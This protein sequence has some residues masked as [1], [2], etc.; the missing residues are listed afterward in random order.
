VSTKSQRGLDVFM[1]LGRRKIAGRNR[2]MAGLLVLALAGVIGV[3]AYAFTASNSVP[4]QTAGAGVGTVSGYTVSSPLNYTFSSDG[5]KMTKVT[6]TLD[7]SASDIKVALSAAA[8]VTADWT[9]C[10]EAEAGEEVTCTFPGEGV[11]DGEGD[12]LSVAAV[13]TGTVTIE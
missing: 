1:H 4:A 7:K 6:F 5:T 12:K 10:G 2:K 9:D 11:A 3:G 8:P 13:G